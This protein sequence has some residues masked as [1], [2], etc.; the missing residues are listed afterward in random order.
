M[1]RGVCSV[2]VEKLCTRQTFSG[3]PLL[4]ARYVA[5]I[6]VEMRTMRSVAK[7]HA[8][9]LEPWRSGIVQLGSLPPKSQNTTDILTVQ[10]FAGNYNNRSSMLDRDE[11]NR[12]SKKP[13]SI[14]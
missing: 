12:P 11:N 9:E 13:D 1:K 4:S 10:I 8:T 14:R 2:S 5:L 3:F 7:P 6:T